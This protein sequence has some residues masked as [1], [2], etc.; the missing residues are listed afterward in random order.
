MNIIIRKLFPKYYARKIGVEF[1]EKCNF[2]N[3]SWGSEPYLIKIGKNVTLSNVS[4]NTHDG[5]CRVIRDEYP[6]V[7]LIEPITIGSNVFIGTNAII[8]PG[9]VIEDNT[10]IGAGT[11]VTSKIY[12]GGNV[13]A[14]NPAK[15]ICSLAEWV[16]KNNKRFKETKG[17]NF[18]EKKRFYKELYCDPRNS[19]S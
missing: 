19:K 16:K 2:I 7:D 17:M 3:V 8:L 13:Y 9:V 14:G 12:I 15:K 6:G 1:G 18:E 5:S 11:I 10:I 4:F